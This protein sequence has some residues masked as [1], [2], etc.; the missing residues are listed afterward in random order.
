MTVGLAAAS[1]VEFV[2]LEG[3]SPVYLREFVYDI[4]AAPVARRLAVARWRH[5]VGAIALAL[6]IH[7]CEMF[8]EEIK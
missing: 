4:N 5:C 2:R 7:K 6:V 1:V 3:V 8:L